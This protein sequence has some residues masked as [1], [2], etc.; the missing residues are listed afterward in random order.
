MHFTEI[1]R[2]KRRIDTHHS[3]AFGFSYRSEGCAFARLIMTTSHPHCG[4]EYASSKNNL[5]VET[6]DVILME[7]D[8]LIRISRHRVDLTLFSGG[9]RHGGESIAT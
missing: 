5:A 1:L 3:T 6:A 9:M 2:L 7:T 8:Y 4:E